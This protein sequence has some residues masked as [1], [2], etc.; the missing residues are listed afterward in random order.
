MQTEA[1]Q[2]SVVSPLA[3][4]L[5]SVT[6]ATLTTASTQAAAG[7]VGR[8]LKDPWLAEGLDDAEQLRYIIGYVLDSDVRKA[9]F[10][11][12]LNRFF[13]AHTALF[14]KAF[15]CCGKTAREVFF[16]RSLCLFHSSKQLSDDIRF[17]FERISG[18][19]EG[20]MQA[21]ICI[22]IRAV[23]EHWSSIVTAHQTPDEASFKTRNA[24][25]KLKLMDAWRFGGWF[26]QKVCK[27]C[28]SLG[29]RHRQQDENMLPALH[30]LRRDR[31]KDLILNPINRFL[32]LL[33]KKEL[34]YPTDEFANLV[35]RIR[36]KIFEQFQ[37]RFRQNR[38][39]V[40][41]D[42]ILQDKYLEK[43]WKKL[44]V[45]N[46]RSK[47]WYTSAPPTDQLV[48]KYW[49]VLVRSLVH[50]QAKEDLHHRSLRLSRAGAIR[51]YLKQLT[52]TKSLAPATSS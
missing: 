31:N 45:D 23:Y 8:L 32:L 33:E 36:D 20:Q 30:T 38:N 3:P 7:I 10:Q 29:D 39:Q 47:E 28:A 14:M 24:S 43:D 11:I 2:T 6:Q 48:G 22:V 17:F 46:N 44:I 25:L 27:L 19:T 35:V 26:I 50:A 34:Q 4:T 12:A 5:Q 40:V 1:A 37:G 13:E 21:V 15:Y 9:P 51:Q 42:A 52:Q 18:V 16:L 49:K 41:I